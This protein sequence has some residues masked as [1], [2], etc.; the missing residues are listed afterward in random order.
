MSKNAPPVNSQAEKYKNEGNEFFKQGNFAKAIENYTFSIEIDSKN[1]AYWNNRAAAYLKMG[2]TQK[3]LRDA[4][5]ATEIDPGWDKG[6]WRKGTVHMA[7]KEYGPA[8]EAFRKAME[9][10]PATASY[11]RDFDEAARN[12][13]RVEMLKIEANVLY[14]NGRFAQAVEKY[15]AA[16][17]AATA[18]QKDL[19]ADILNNMAACCLQQEAYNMDKVIE[20]TTQALELRPNDSKALLRRGQ[21]FEALEKY[22]KALADFETVLRMHPENQ[23]AGAAVHRIRKAMAAYGM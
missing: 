15:E 5:K 9:I 16:L 3:A 1:A 10:S 18:E 12:V 23:M 7:L 21:A 2:D 4:V 6:Y 22:K 17:S 14:K 11:K 13:P 20:C 8:V 19:K